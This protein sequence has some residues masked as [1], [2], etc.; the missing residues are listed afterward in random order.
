MKVEYIARKSRDVVQNVMTL[1]DVVGDAGD[2]GEDVVR[3]AG[4]DV[5]D[6]M[7]SRVNRQRTISHTCC[8]HGYR[9][10]L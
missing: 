1:W 4:E 10:Q 9:Q 8:C 5:Q 3:D 6:A 2:A 7:C